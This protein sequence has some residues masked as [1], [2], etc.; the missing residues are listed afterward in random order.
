MK[1]TLATGIGFVAFLAAGGALAQ[2]ASYG[3]QQAAAPQTATER[4]PAGFE[5]SLRLGGDVPLGDGVKDGK[6]SDAFSIQFPLLL[7]LG[8][9]VTPHL[10]LGA[11]GGISFG[12]AGSEGDG[13][14]KG[15]ITCSTN[16]YQLGAQAQWRFLP[17]DNSTPW[18]GY[19]IG[20]EWAAGTVS[21]NDKSMTNTVSGLDFAKIMVGWDFRLADLLYVGPFVNFTLGQYGTSTLS[22]DDI[23]T[24][25]TDI[26]HK[27]IHEWLTFGV[28]G[29]LVL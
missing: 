17:E 10:F 1:T 5:V 18:V 27:A 25:S 8:G 12:G 29:A 28:R 22:G 2:E 16:V 21:A 9:R 23:D 11:Y 7:D 13:C 6:M 3:D 26:E 15:G 14:G 20:W 4:T 19:G 24:Q